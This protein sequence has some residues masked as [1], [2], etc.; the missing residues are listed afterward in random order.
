MLAAGAH[1]G[2]CDVT[3]VDTESS[4]PSVRVC[5]PAADGSCGNVLYTGALNLGDSENVCTSGETIV[6]QEWS[7]Q[8]AAYAA[9]VSAF[10]D[11]GVVEL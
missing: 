3:K 4:A 9:P 10:C 2:C 5:E 7:D 1:A 6:Y 8:E 11:G